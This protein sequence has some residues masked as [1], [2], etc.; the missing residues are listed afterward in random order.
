MRI[1]SWPQKFGI[2]ACWCCWYLLSSIGLLCMCG[3]EFIRSKVCVRMMVRINTLYLPLYSVCWMGPRTALKTWKIKER[4]G[5]FSLNLLEFL[6]WQALQHAVDK[7]KPVTRWFEYQ[8]FSTLF[9][10]GMW[11]VSFCAGLLLDLIG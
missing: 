5:H 11:Y 1:H 3:G 6:I 10:S 2:K 9:I 7:L 4:I 8:W